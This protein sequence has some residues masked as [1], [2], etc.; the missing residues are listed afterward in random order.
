M[1]RK[2]LLKLTK[3]RRRIGFMK[4]EGFIQGRIHEETTLSW[5]AGD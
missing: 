1:K 2:E 5:E 3:R 4:K